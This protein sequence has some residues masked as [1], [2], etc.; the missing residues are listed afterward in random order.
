MLDQLPWQFQSLV[1]EVA[2]VLARRRQ[3]IQ[4]QFH[5]EQPL[6]PTGHEQQRAQWIAQRTAAGKQEAA[7]ALFDPEDGLVLANAQFRA[8]HDMQPAARTFGD[9]MRH[10]HASRRGPRIDT[11]DIEAWLSSAD[12]K[13]R[14]RAYRSFR[15]DLC[16]G[17]VYRV[18][19][20][21]FENGWLLYVSS[22][23]QPFAVSVTAPFG[24]DA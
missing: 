8:L 6:I 21:S 18:N 13:R 20:T 7:I 5:R 2:I 14:S 1:I 11:D 10:C 23:A 22:P 9:I 24:A 12:T 19:E 3:L 4:V 16:D 15:I 17:R